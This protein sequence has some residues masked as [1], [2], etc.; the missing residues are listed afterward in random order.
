ML[1]S[2]VNYRL[3]D[4]GFMFNIFYSYLFTYNNI[5][6]DFHIGWGSCHTMGGISVAGT[7]YIPQQLSLPQVHSY[8][9]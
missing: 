4:K 2:S 7:S 1:G 5:Q 3:F 6:K 8:N 9:I